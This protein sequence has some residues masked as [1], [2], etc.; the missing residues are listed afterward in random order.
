MTPCDKVAASETAPGDSTVQELVQA[1][2]DRLVSVHAKRATLRCLRDQSVEAVR[3][4]DT[5]V[6]ALKSMLGDM[7]RSFT[8]RWYQK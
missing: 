6:F 3:C 8:I 4:S 1:A 2:E 5:L 7:P